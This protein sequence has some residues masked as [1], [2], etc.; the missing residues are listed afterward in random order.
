M[1]TTAKICLFLGLFYIPFL[2]IY[3]YFTEWKEPVGT[4]GLALSSG[5]GLMVWGYLA[6]TNKKLNGLPGDDEHGEISDIQGEYGFFSPHSWWPLW[7][8]ASL[9]MLSLGVA[10]GWWMVMV[11]VPLVLIS[12]VGWVFV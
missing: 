5:F 4:V 7:L 11:A 10:V 6:I 2:F 1:K 3:G 9:S 12:V 8:A